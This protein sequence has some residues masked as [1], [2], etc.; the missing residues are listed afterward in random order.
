MSSLKNL[1][2]PSTANNAIIVEE[3]FDIHSVKINIIEA[4]CFQEEN[5]ETRS[6]HEHTTMACGVITLLKFNQVRVC[7]VLYMFALY[8]AAPPG[9]Y[10]SV[11]LCQCPQ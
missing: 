1:I 6:T 4:Q 8:Y 9:S 2:L 10:G 3:N 11:E 5:H 7:S